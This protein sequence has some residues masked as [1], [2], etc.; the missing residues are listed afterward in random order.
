[1]D[2]DRNQRLSTEFVVRLLADYGIGPPIHGLDL[3]QRAFV[4]SD[5]LESL[6]TLAHTVHFGYV[7]VDSNERLELLGDR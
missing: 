6:S 4:S 7:P 5:Y 2:N 3:Y 1:M